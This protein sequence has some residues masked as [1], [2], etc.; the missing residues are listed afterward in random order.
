MIL[1][2]ILV[3]KLKNLSLRISDNF[4]ICLFSRILFLKANQ[5]MFVFK[6]N[7]FMSSDNVIL[8]RRLLDEYLHY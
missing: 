2:I 5:T 4:F 3:D 6:L 1:Y 7:K 8:V